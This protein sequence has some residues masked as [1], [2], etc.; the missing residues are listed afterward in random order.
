MHIRNPHLRDVPRIRDLAQALPYGNNEFIDYSL[1]EDQYFP[2]IKSPY[3]LIAELD[4]NIQGYVMGY[5]LNHLPQLFDQD[6]YAS[7]D[8][9]LYWYEKNSDPDSV[10]LEQIGV[11]VPGTSCA[12]NLLTSLET[13]AKTSKYSFIYCGIHNSNSRSQRF[14]KRAGFEKNAELYDM[15]MYIKK[16][17]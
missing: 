10:Y 9:I 13:R 7:Q 1:E 14:F 17:D 3:S 15:G 11:K 16:L 12:H 4:R 8:P 5:S 6:R 2:R